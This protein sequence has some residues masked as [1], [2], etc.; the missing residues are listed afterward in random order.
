MFGVRQDKTGHVCLCLFGCC[1]LL[2]DGVSVLLNNS[3]PLL[4]ET[5]VVSSTF[6]RCNC[7]YLSIYSDMM[8]MFTAQSA[9]AVVFAVG[10]QSPLPRPTTTPLLWALHSLFL[11]LAP[12][13][14]YKEENSDVEWIQSYSVAAVCWTVGVNHFQCVSVKCN[15]STFRN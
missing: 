4:R 5:V 14:I 1:C 6:R 12:V 9:A 11:L 3:P 10:L 2:F 13:F 8:V 15:L 7:I